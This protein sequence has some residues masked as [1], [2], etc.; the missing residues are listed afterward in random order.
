MAMPTSGENVVRMVVQ[1]VTGNRTEGYRVI[2]YP[3]RQG[4]RTPF[5]FGS[6]AELVHRLREAIPDF[7]ESRVGSGSGSTEIIF[8]ETME[9]SDDQLKKLFAR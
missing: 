9:V 3:K 6:R 4:F 5:T 8:A 7:D 2:L 1:Y